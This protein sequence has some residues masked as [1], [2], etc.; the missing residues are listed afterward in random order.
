MSNKVNGMKVFSIETGKFK[1][2]GGAMF[3]VVPKVLWE[4][5]YPADQQNLCSCACRSMLIVD[6]NRKILIDTGIGNKLP[7]EIAKHYHMFGQDTL[8][9][10]LEKVNV[11]PEDIT[12]IVLTHL[13][14][15]HCGGT[16]EKDDK[17]R[18]YPVFPNAEVVISAAQWESAINPNLR[19]KPAYFKDNFMPVQDAGKLKLLH[20]PGM[21]TKN[22]ELRLYNG[23][24]KG[25]ISA[26][27][28]TGKKRI[29]FAG[30]VL[31]ALPYIRLPYIS[32][33]DIHPLVTLDEKQ[34][35]INEL[36]SNDDVL[37]LQHDIDN[38]ACT[39]KDTKKGI[40]EDK[41][42]KLDEII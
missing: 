39:L 23:H 8:L 19:E 13:H 17:D 7:A 26:F 25:L 28:N 10:S 22:I 20:K 5:L 34:A 30:D 18:L 2:D 37:F 31:P 32:A 27:I 1:V 4:R 41:V 15:D 42:F 14:F 12:D 40:R 35:L 24:T 33:Y 11:M 21:L 3:G 6:D 36:Y 38:E 9:G 29:V 16:T